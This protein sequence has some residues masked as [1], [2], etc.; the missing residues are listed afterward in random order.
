M[1]T[2]GKYVL[3]KEGSVHLVA[4]MTISPQ[5]VW[6]ALSLRYGILDPNLPPLHMVGKA[7][8][9]SVVTH[10]RVVSCTTHAQIHL[11]N[12]EIFTTPTFT[13]EMSHN[14]TCPLI[15]I[16]AHVFFGSTSTQRYRFQ[17]DK[18]ILH[19]PS[20]FHDRL[21]IHSSQVSNRHRSNMQHHVPQYAA[22]ISARCRPQTI[23]LPSISL[24][25]LETVGT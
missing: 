5:S 18:A 23:P 15:L 14:M 1:P 10:E 20:T 21:S 13:S 9:D 7:R 6:K 25:K 24:W 11:A 17:P 12:R 3:L 19:N 4:A 16:V 22:I 8:M 2:P